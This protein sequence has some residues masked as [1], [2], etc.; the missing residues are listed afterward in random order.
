VDRCR[1]AGIV[2]VVVGEARSTRK[3]TLKTIR[4]PS[5]PRESIDECH[6]LTV[7]MAL[8]ALRRNVMRSLLTCL[9]S[10]SASLRYCHDGIGQ[11]SSRSIQKAIASLAQT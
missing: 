8:H 6:Y 11:G 1:F 9:E 4:S 10:S 2:E 3:P 7:R 5:S